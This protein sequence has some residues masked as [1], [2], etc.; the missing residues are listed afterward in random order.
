M[1]TALSVSVAV[2]LVAA[3]GGSSPPPK[4]TSSN[5]STSGGGTY[6]SSSL[7]CAPA[8]HVHHYD[9]HDEDG[10]DAMVPCS[11]SGKNDYAGLIHIETMADGVHITIH[12][13]DDQ[14]NLGELGKD[15]K[16][17]DAVIV[18]P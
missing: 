4:T 13:T 11:K 14:V 18:Y 8:D 6:D 5:A 16:Q 10:D 2:F 7:K 17:R 3:C 9:L 1:R 15:V 12:A